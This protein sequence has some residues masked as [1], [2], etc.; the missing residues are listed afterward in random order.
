M[1]EN[2]DLT[3][4]LEKCPAGFP[5]YYSVGRY[6]EFNRIEDGKV[7]IDVYAQ[8]HT[9]PLALRSDGRMFEDGDCLIFP[10]K[11]QR[12]W[13]KFEAPW[14]KHGRYGR[15]DPNALKPFDK[16]LARSTEDTKWTAGIFSYFNPNEFYQYA[17]AGNSYRFCIPYNKETQHLLGTTHAAPEYYR[18]Y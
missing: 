7:V 6:V 8:N 11:E 3:V 12:D 15:F 4:I 10:S 13:N 1:N 17:C 9:E 16:V 5:L 2:I 14:Y 18:I